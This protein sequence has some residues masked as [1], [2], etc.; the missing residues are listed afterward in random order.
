M[1]I[2]KSLLA[3]V[4]AVMA[5]MAL[6]SAA[7]AAEDGTLV[8]QEGIITIPAG[9]VLHSIGWAKFATAAGSLE[10]H[11][12][13]TVEATG[14]SG[15]TADVTAFTVPDTSK[16]TGTGLFQNC[17]MKTEESK[18]LPY[19]ATV[20][21]DGKVDVT[22]DIEIHSTYSKCLA[23]T[24]L[25]TLSEVTLT[26]LK[27]GER[28]VTGTA[29]KLGETAAL[30]EP[31]SGVEIGGFT[32]KG[33]VHI[34]SSLGTKSTEA[35]KSVSGEFELTEGDRGTWA[36]TEDGTLVDQEGIITIPAGTVLHSIGWAKFATA[37]G[38]LE[39][40]V[41]ATV[42]ATGASGTTADVTA[43]TVPDTSKC[44]GT[45]ALKGCTMKTDESKNL[46][47][48]AT[49]TSD[50]RI[51]ITG[52]IE[53][54]GT[55]SE[56]LV[57]TTLLTLS[58]VTLTPLKAGEK[59]VTGT[60]GKLGETAALNEPIAG[61]EIGGFTAKGEVH[62]ESSFGTKSTEAL[63]S[64]SGEFELT[65]GDRGTWAVTEDG[66]L[67]DQ[68]GIITIP[69][70]T[71]L[72]SIGWAKFATAAGS[73]EC[74]VTAT[75]E[76]TGASGTTADV[77]AFT[78]PDTSKCTGTGLFQNCNMKTEES[79]NL[80]YHA[81]VTSDGKVDVTGDIE[82]HSTYSKC[83]AKTT[84][85]TLSEV[86]LTPLKAGER[87]VTGTAGKL[88]ET[89]A[90]NEPISGVEIGGFTAKGEVHIES[91]L[92]TKSTEALKSVSGEFELTEGDRGTWAVTAS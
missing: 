33:E 13:A 36:V 7:L 52:N 1:I 80:P 29:G 6:A 26:P 22:G 86:T 4:A 50:G 12:T 77:T 88:G 67:V 2:K 83:L 3:L 23:K 42:E 58:E 76:A 25:L 39:C 48:H 16:C 70:G 9:T 89:A 5:S 90:L 59:A 32:A 66:T 38:S 63:K 11:V 54:H 15:T 91:S 18:N 49:V 79:K 68:E 62:I 30:N 72:H 20:T 43:F 19:H 35:L 64:V 8:D 45:G 57:K 74:H 69:A 46:P 17:N 31:I 65:E 82:I 55:Y 47:Y 37:A 71:V 81:T 41:T 53:I 24:T 44:T 28:A 60:E 84:L 56:C 40:H 73:L 10:C 34:E 92:G 87:A 14:A 21:S 51:D 75:V 61:V 78:V 85:L 27:A